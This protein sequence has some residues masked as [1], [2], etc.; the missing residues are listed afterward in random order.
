MSELKIFLKSPLIIII[1]IIIPTDNLLWMLIMVTVQVFVGGYSQDQCSA[2]FLYLDIIFL[3]KPH[4]SS[5]A[6]LNA[7]CR[8]DFKLELVICEN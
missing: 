7:A 4:E 2:I 1:I 6:C 5:G 3:V 8:N